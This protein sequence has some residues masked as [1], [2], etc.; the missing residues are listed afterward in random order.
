MSDQRKR[1]SEISEAYCQQPRATAARAARV[2]SSARCTP[3]SCRMRAVCAVAGSCRTRLAAAACN[4]QREQ[5]LPVARASVDVFRCNG[6]SK[7]A[8]EMREQSLPFVEMAAGEDARKKNMILG[9]YGFYYGADDAHRNQRRFYEKWQ[10]ANEMAKCYILAS[11]SNIL[12]TKHQNLETATEIMD[13][14]QQMFGQST[15]S[16]RQAALKGI[17][18][19]KMGKGTRVR[20]HVL[21]MM[22]YLNEAEIQGAQIDDN[23][24]IDMVL[25]SLPET[26]KEFKV[27]YNMNKRNMTLTELMNELHSAE[28]I[29]RAEKSLGSINI[30]EKSSSSGPKP[31]GKGKKKAGKKRPSTNQDGKPK[32]KCFKCGQKGHWKKDCPKIVKSGMG[33][34]FVIEACLVQNPIDTWVLDS[35]ATNHICNSLYWF[36]ETRKISEGSVKLQLGTGR[37]VSAVKT[38]SVLLSFNNETLVLNNC[39]Y[40]PDI[41]RNLISVACLSKQGYTVNFGSSVS[42]FHNKRLICSGTLEDNLYHLSPMIH[43]MHDTVI[44]NDEHTHLSKKRNISSNQH[45]LW[46]LRLGHINQNRIQRMIKDGLLGPLEN[47]SLP[48]CESCLEGKMTKRPFSAKGVRATVPLELV[49]TDVCG[50]INVQ[51]RGGY[52]YFITFTDDYSRYGYVYLMHHKSEALEKFKEYRAE[53]EKQ[54]DKNIKKLR[55]DRGGEF[56]S[57]DF[58]EYLVENEIISQLT[59]P[60]TPQQNGV[61]ERRNRTLLDMVRS[62]LSYSSLP[63]SFW[64]LALETAVYLLNLVPSKSVP[65]TP[66]ELWS[67]RKLSLRHVR[68]WGSPAHV[69]KPKADKMDSRSEVCIFVGYPKGTRGGLFYSPQDRK[70]IVSTHFTSL[71][72]DYMN[73][74][75]P[76]SKVIHEELSGDQVDAQLSMPVIE[77][78]EQQQP[79]DQHRI[80]T[81]QPSLLEPRR[82]GRVTRL[83][84]RY[85]LLGETY[86]A[87]SDEHVQDPTSY[88][89]ALIDRDVEFWKKAMNQEMESMYSNKVWEL[90]EPPNGVKPIGCKWIYKRKRG[91]DGRVET[92]KARLV[93]KGFTQKEGIDYEE[94]FSPVA[95]LK[96]IRILLSIAAVLDY[97]IWQMDVKTAF[98]NGHLEENIYMQQPDGFIQKGQEH[99][100]CKLQRSIYGLKQASRSWNI[101]FDQAIKSFGFI[102]N[103]DEPCV[104]KKIQEKS[105]SFL[106]L[107]VDDILLIGNDIGVLTTIKSWLAKQFDM[108]DLGEASYI[109]GIKLLRDRKNKTLALS[110]AVYIDKILARF[111]MENSKT[112]LLPFRHGITFSKDQS[113][114]TSEEIERMRRVPYAEAVGSL[115][116]AMLCT[117]PDICFAVGMVS[118]YQSNPGP[119][120]WTA[121][122]HIMKYLKRTKNYMLVYSGDELIPVGYTDSDFMSDKDSRKS[123]SGY[124]FT[125]GSGAISWRSVKQSCI[126]DSTT[127]AEYVAAS[128]AAKEAV[129]LSK[130]LQDLEVVPTVTAPLK[131]FCDN[132]GAVAQSKEPRNHK[133]QKHIERKYHLI[134]DIVH[135]GDVEVTQIASQ[136]NLTDPFTKAIPGKPFNLHLESMGMREMPNML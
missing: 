135:R 27:N 88:N 103:I 68:I 52:E 11:I 116:Y 134:R 65:K 94:T 38:G 9:F 30:T 37:F 123:T 105:V 127:E 53:K 117:R 60:G 112:G 86:T 66:I 17:M 79:D 41:K 90:V 3:S 42:I 31:K 93:A 87:I 131:L 33:N 1:R 55:S 113:P 49:H 136:Q 28:K 57:G 130:F 73:N 10:K 125:L 8:S 100:V 95:M 115:M 72:E 81:E 74:F 107:Y 124:V 56:L 111:S 104:Y 6:G 29:Y 46:H 91:V 64:G 106:I 4:Q 132:S 120:H 102:Q 118:R 92:F 35:G 85:M 121:V 89:E 63:I 19:S 15:R 78:E 45:Y 61:A 14:L 80:N 50:P 32:G 58:K 96:S 70:V 133:K 76:K 84:A 126:A 108:K 77:E 24:K 99:M 34:L 48:L 109:L 18:N 128:E 75:K 2:G 67:G 47:E 40:V 114:K 83:P 26:F 21:K 43:S 97:E 101:R 44:N 82:S 59:A 71:E 23:S 54:L 98:L 16:A 39:L 12:Q 110:Q 36:Q 62:M 69:L 122:K 25:E 22:D 119:E 129:W 13:S 5:R 20:D 7:S 51:A